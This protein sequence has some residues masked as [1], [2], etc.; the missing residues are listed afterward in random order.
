MSS[1]ASVARHPIACHG[2]NAFPIVGVRYQS[3]QVPSI[4][5]CKS[6]AMSPKWTKAHSPFAPHATPP[7]HRAG[8]DGCNASP[9]V[10]PRAMSTKVANF[11]LCN[12]CIRGGCWEKSH[13]PFTIVHGTA[14]HRGAVCRGCKASPIQGPR[15]IST[16]QPKFD[17]CAS[18]AGTGRWNQT[19]GPFRILIKPPAVHPGIGCDGCAKPVIGPRYQSTKNPNFDLCKR[20]HDTTRYTANYGPFLVWAVPAVHAG[21]GCDG[22]HVAPIAGTRFYCTDAENNYDFCSACLTKGRNAG[23]T[24]NFMSLETPAMHQGIYCNG[25]SIESIYG[26]RYRSLTVANYDLCRDCVAKDTSCG[27]FQLLTQPATAS[28]QV[29]D[30]VDRLLDNIDAALDLSDDMMYL[31]ELAMDAY[32]AAENVFS[33]FDMDDDSSSFL[34]QC[35][36][37]LTLSDDTATDDTRSSENNEEDDNEDE[38]A[39]HEGEGDGGDEYANYDYEDGVDG[40]C[41]DEG[42]IV[43]S[44]VEATISAA[45]GARQYVAC[46]SCESGITGRRFQSMEH[47]NYSFCKPCGQHPKIAEV[48]APYKVFR[49]GRQRRRRARKAK[50]SDS[51][52]EDSD[53]SSEESESD[54]DEE[55]ED[56]SD[57]DSDDNDSNEERDSEAESDDADDGD[58]DDG[59]YDGGDYQDTDYDYTD[60]YDGGDY[61][62]DDSATVD[63]GSFFSFDSSSS[64]F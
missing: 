31:S 29:A 64:F 14:I 26:I 25:C 8:C 59:D 13:G 40:G 47:A 49:D 7:T 27:P 1:T 61:N 42:D 44:L 15:L 55:P 24:S 22:C 20:C 6:C 38:Y 5:L 58:Y 35:I 36:D 51:S 62:Y 48:F 54:D 21:V 57:A 19:H 17:L 32:A 39:A 34:E 45:T 2:C 56:E 18:C 4:D 16:R 52:S 12:G 11:D 3:T 9:I 23:N 46:H 28:T 37:A 63:S 33:H 30:A 10:G 53:S 60:G 41:E 43:A 50:D